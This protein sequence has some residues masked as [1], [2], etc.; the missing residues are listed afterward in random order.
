[1]SVIILKYTINNGTE[2]IK[3]LKNDESCSRFVNKSLKQSGDAL[4]VVSKTV[5]NRPKRTILKQLEIPKRGS[6]NDSHG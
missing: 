3:L 2:Q 1:M 4:F 5:D 6:R